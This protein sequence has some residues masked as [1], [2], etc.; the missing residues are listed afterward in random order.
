MILN[1]QP[2]TATSTFPYTPVG[3]V[4]F[5]HLNFVKTEQTDYYYGTGS[6]ANQLLSTVKQTY[7]PNIVILEIGGLII[8]F[9]CVLGFFIM[10][11]RKMGK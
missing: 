10:K 3:P 6:A 5:S 11:I 4:D 9:L 1:G 2:V 7:D 8:L